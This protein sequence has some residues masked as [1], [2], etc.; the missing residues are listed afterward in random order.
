MISGKD[1]GNIRY[2]GPTGS[3]LTDK[4]IYVIWAAY[5]SGNSAQPF[6]TTEGLVAPTFTMHSRLAFTDD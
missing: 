2:N 5:A 4:G 6:D 1:I 3:A